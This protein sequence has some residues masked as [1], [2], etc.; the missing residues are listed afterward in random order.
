MGPGPFAKNPRSG[1]VDADL[2]W[3]RRGESGTFQRL[4]SSGKSS[5]ESWHSSSS[6]FTDFLL[7]C[8]EPRLLGPCGAKPGERRGE[9]LKGIV[10]SG[11][12][13]DLLYEGDGDRERGLAE[14][15]NGKEGVEGLVN[16]LLTGGALLGRLREPDDLCPIALFTCPRRLGKPGLFAVVSSLVDV[17]CDVLCLIDPTE[18]IRA[19]GRF[20][21]VCLSKAYGSV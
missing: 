17:I 1:L 4:V 5:S 11:T 15:G 21:I 7:G 9:L 10:E 2:C 20:A 3:G 12:T 19:T 16:P 6:S 8:Q 18:T 13:T 14:D